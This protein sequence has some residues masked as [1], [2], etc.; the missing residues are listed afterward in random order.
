MDKM[1]RALLVERDGY[2]RRGLT[3]RVEAVD[4]AL[5]GYGYE[6]F[7]LPETATAEPVAETAAKPRGRRR[8]R[9]E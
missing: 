1:I 6:V 7:D 2:R 5:R 4:E 3:E 9:K 8:K